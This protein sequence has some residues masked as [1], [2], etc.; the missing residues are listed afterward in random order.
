MSTYAAV[1]Q[2]AGVIDLSTRGR[3]VVRGADRKPF[4][5]ALLTNDIVA[6][7]A[8]TGCYAALLTPQGRMVA[9]MRVLE[10]GDVILID[11]DRSVKDM[12]LARFDALIFSEDVQLG[13]LSD[14]WGCVGIYGPSAAAVAAHAAL[15]LSGEAADALAGSL[16]A[17]APFGNLRL[18]ARGEV[19]VA[20][21]DDGFGLPG[22]LVFA[23]LGVVPGIGSGAM[24]GGAVALDDA[25]AEVL[26]VEA[27]EPVFPVDLTT[28]TIPPE[29]G[30]ESRLISFTKG[31]YPGQ[32]VIVRIRDRGHGRV[33]HRLVGLAVAG[34]VVPARGDRVFLGEKDSGHVT[35]AVMS[36]ARG[37]VL[38][39]G[40]VRRDLAENGTKVLV[41]HEGAS[42]EAEVLPLPFPKSLPE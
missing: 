11:C 34:G 40:Y 16:A 23:P 27:G 35:S 30:I 21:R 15:G 28:D 36:P 13:D 19:L 41:L 33:A 14:A 10:L 5:H 39:L 24:A 17:L 26:R 9:D 18:E 8:G 2:T 12:L 37:G 3:I 4:L 32:E 22:F 29:A 7:Q 25:T 42:L 6:L 20:A 38:A 1:R 31:C